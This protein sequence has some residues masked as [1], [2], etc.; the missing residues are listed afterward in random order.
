MALPARPPSDPYASLPIR[1]GLDEHIAL[2][3]MT[4]S[5]KTFRAKMILRAVPRK[6]VLDSKHTYRDVGARIVRRYS[7]WLPYQVFRAG[8]DLDAYDAF[9]RDAWRDRRPV[10]LYVDETFDLSSSSRN[11]VRPLGRF[12][13]EGRER[14]QRVMLASQQP[15]NIPSVVFTES[16]HIFAF[17]INWAG[18][19]EK[20]EQFTGDGMAD[21]IARLQGHDYYY[22]S[23]HE[24]VPRYRAAAWDTAETIVAQSVTVPRRHW[25]AGLW[26]RV[27][28]HA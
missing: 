21:G 27:R 10:T 12:I 28:G 18:H 19:R 3:G 11:L 13:R 25:W 7:P 17:Y 8:D 24:R 9:L 22:F 26:G 6:I 23:T 15:S 20:V 5:G 2:F 1:L 14:H 16:T 4:G